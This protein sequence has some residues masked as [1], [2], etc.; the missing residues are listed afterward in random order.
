VFLPRPAAS[1]PFPYTTL[2]RSEF[3]DP[4][5]ENGVQDLVEAVPGPSLPGDKRF[6]PVVFGFHIVPSSRGTKGTADPAPLGKGKGFQRKRRRVTG[7][8]ETLNRTALFHEKRRRTYRCLCCLC[9]LMDFTR[10]KTS[11][12]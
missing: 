3:A 12:W 5:L 9:W 8:K 6:Q 1:P 4:L 10:I 2:F 11:R 7:A